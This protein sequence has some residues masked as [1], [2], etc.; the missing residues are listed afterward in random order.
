MEEKEK[1]VCRKGDRQVEEGEN[2]VQ[3]S[4]MKLLFSLSTLRIDI[5][6]NFFFLLL[7]EPFVC[8]A[9][10]LSPNPNFISPVRRYR[11]VLSSLFIFFT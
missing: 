11:L 9:L 6:P 7:S 10:S 8:P 3:N 5:L 2:E 1:H 4:K